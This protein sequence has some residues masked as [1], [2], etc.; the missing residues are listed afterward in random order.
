MDSHTRMLLKLESCGLCGFVHALAKPLQLCKRMHQAHA[1]RVMV[2][3][4]G[5][6]NS[7]V[8]GHSHFDHTC[9]LCAAQI[10]AR[11]GQPFA[12]LQKDPLSPRPASGPAM[13]W[14]PAHGLWKDPET[15]S[16][17]QEPCMT[18]EQVCTGRSTSI[19]HSKGKA[20]HTAHG[21]WKDPETMIRP[22]G[23]QSTI[24]TNVFS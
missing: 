21:L 24:L 3:T 8:D 11:T 18:Y 17:L 1:L 5:C 19:G 10:S 4:K 15:M 6:S 12:A 23:W 9:L 20:F 7:T 16:Q 2:N 13:G 14:T 22:A